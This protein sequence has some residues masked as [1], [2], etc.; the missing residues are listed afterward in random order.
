MARILVIDDEPEWLELLR[1]RLLALGHEVVAVGDPV[2]ILMEVVMGKP[3]LV[4]LDIRMPISGRVMMKSVR[5]NDPNVPVI[6]HTAYGGYEDDPGFAGAS[7]FVVKTPDLK[8]LVTAVGNLLGGE[9][10][11]GVTVH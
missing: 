2:K 1:E 11:A 7:A 6:V 9:A 5:G 4:V 10:N 3:D 8:G